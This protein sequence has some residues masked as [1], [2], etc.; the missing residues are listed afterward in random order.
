MKLAIELNPLSRIPILELEEFLVVSIQT[1]LHDKSAQQFQRDLVHKL[2]KT[3]A[4]GV[5]I[6]VTALEVVDSFLGRLIGD[7]A[8]MCH[9]MG[10]KTVVTGISP[11]IAITL[12]E[13]G[14]TLDTVHT[15]LN[16]EKGISWLQNQT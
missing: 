15:T 1:E 11:A 6:D 4:K 3:T 9:M 5:V 14:I 12:T 8:K 7:T 13:L 10:A 2:N 16:M